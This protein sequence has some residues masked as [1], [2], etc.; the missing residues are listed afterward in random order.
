LFTGCGTGGAAE[1]N[2]TLVYPPWKHTW[3]VVRATPFKLRLFVGDKTHFNDPQGI[4]CVRL[5]SWDDPTRTSDDDELTVYGVNSGDNCIIYNRSM[6]SLGIYGLDTDHAKFDRPWGIAADAKGNVYVVDRGNARVVRLFNPGKGLQFVGAIGGPGDEPGC[7]V[8][9]CGVAL[10]SDGV[11]YVTDAALG[12]VTIFDDS[13]RVVDVWEGFDSPDGIAV[14]TPDERSSFYRNDGFAVVIDSLN[15]RV[16]KLSLK[17]E[18]LGETDAASWGGQD[19]CLG[20]IVLD[21]HNQLLVT[22]RSGGCIHKLDRNLRYLTRFGQPG[23]GRYRFDEPR[24]IAT[25][26]HFG[27]TFVVERKGAH[28]FWVGVYVPRFEVQVRADS[29]R[30]ELDVDFFLTEPAFC[31][32]DILD[33]FGR[34]ITRLV[35]QRR[36]P[37]GEGHLTWGLTVPKPPPQGVAYTAPPPE[38]RPDERLPDGEY[39]LHALFRAAYSSREDFACEVEAKFSLDSE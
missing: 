1:R 14:V 6:F 20:Y 11:I 34:F 13:G 25:Y 3:G 27:Q 26:R 7:F 30:R 15:Q 36:Y 21:Y 31:E 38:Y 16:R 22:D 8:D 2:T 17:G 12:R 5:Q 4:A 32:I 39:T 37:S 23:Q 10:D 29:V 33:S 19:A 9:P 24:G 28:Y 18:L 35:S